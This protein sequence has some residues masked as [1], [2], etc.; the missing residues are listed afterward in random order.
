M[1]SGEVRTRD[2]A[3]LALAHQVVERAQR[4]LY[5]RGRIEG[6]QMID[7]DVVRPQPLQR[8][9]RRLNKVVPRRPNIVWP[10]A[11]P[12][13]CLRRDQNI[14]AIQVR[15]G[16]PKNRLALSIRVDIRRVEHID[17]GINADVDDLLRLGDVACRSPR[18]EKLVSATKRSCTEA[19]LRH[20]QT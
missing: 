11:Q 2:V 14:L 6:V 17:P 19:K 5:R 10:F 13:R 1:A 9:L 8:T 3:D 20:L 7:I 18:V 4:L 16:F 15:E 12:E